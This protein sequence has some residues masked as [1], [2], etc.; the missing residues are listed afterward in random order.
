MPAFYSLQR[1]CPPERQST[2][3]RQS[4]PLIRIIARPRIIRPQRSRRWSSRRIILIARRLLSPRRLSRPSRG[5]RSPLRWVGLRGALR[6]RVCRWHRGIIVVVHWRWHW[7]HAVLRLGL[8]W[9]VEYLGVLE[10]GL[11]D[12]A[13]LAV[14]EPAVVGEGCEAFV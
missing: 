5:L 11:V 1:I 14:E 9:V 10:L 4:P 13:L 7:V 12:C 2:T 8:I 6:R 3:P